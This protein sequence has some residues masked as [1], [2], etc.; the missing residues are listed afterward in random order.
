MSE[1][2]KSLLLP[3]QMTVILLF[4]GIF[5]KLIGRFQK[6]STA[7][8]L[9]GAVLY[10]IFS[11]GV[12]A[13]LLISPL[14]YR[15]PFVQSAEVYDDVDTVVLLAGY[16]ADDPLMPLSSQANC[17]SVYRVL[18]SYR[19]FNEGKLERIIVTGNRST[20]TVIRALLVNLGVPQSLIIEDDGAAHTSNSALSIKK[21]IGTKPFF[22][23][24]SAGHMPRSVGVFRRHGMA[25]IPAPTDYQLPKN[26]LDASLMPSPFHLSVSDL[27]VREYGGILWYRFTGEIEEY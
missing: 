25:P 8:L 2:L 14:E 21:Y 17:A 26:F 11:T 5:L 4:V 27:A 22:L 13:S 3:S 1:I 16:A 7:S 15:Y 20:V 18:E 9:S 23:V 6:L 10:I 12:V 19:L 24:T